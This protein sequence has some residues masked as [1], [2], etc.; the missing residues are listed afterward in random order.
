M[1]QQLLT[2]SDDRDRDEQLKN[3]LNEQDRSPAAVRSAVAVLASRNSL[4]DNDIERLIRVSSDTPIAAYSLRMQLGSG[5][6]KTS[7]IEECSR[8][9][10]PSIR[11]AA[12][13][14]CLEDGKVS[15]D[16]QTILLP[17]LT[18]DG[19]EPW[20]QDALLMAF[21][22]DPLMALTNICDHAEHTERETAIMI[23]KLGDVLARQGTTA[24]IAAALRLA[25]TV[26]PKAN[27]ITAEILRGMARGLPRNTDTKLRQPLASLLATP[28][29]DAAAATEYIRQMLEQSATDAVNRE[30]PTSQRL[31][32]ITLLPLRSTDEV[33]QTLKE[34]LN[35]AESG[36]IQ[37]AAI[38]L[39]RQAGG[40]QGAE[41]VITNW[42]HLVPGA[43]KIRP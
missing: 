5:A 8:H 25:Q 21:A 15:V 7:A 26:H 34:L 14:A 23:E 43:K 29:P 38:A 28:P 10:E 6:V 39:A 1:A 30:H 4:H 40:A 42:K 12:I 16:E 13:L 31:A 20:F 19:H 3:W 35:P 36:E 9:A 11:Y 18:R 27:W 41:T 37:Q 32:A 24:S 2:L 17:L 22:D 33:N